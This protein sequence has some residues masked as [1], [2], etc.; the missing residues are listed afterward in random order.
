MGVILDAAALVLVDEGYDRATT[1]RI[2]ERAGVSIGSLYQYFPNRD[3]LFG[4]LHGR[5]EAQMSENIWQTISE[6]EGLDLRGFVRSGLNTA[7]S[8]H[9]RVLPLLKVLMETA[10]GRPPAQWPFDRFPQRQGLLRGMFDSHADE[11]RPGFNREAGS[12]FIPRMVGSALDAAIA[13]RPDAFANGELE[14]ELD[15][16]LS[17]YLLGDR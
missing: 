10:S 13:F 11:L 1:N 2:A 6:F 16:M 9:A 14:Q 3:A 4:A 5:T 17:Y 15:T 7:I 8:Q 12:F